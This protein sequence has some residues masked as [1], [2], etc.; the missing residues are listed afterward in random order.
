MWLSWQRT[1][2]PTAIV[3]DETFGSATVHFRIEPA[4][5]S[6]SA[7]AVA[8]AEKDTAKRG[9]ERRRVESMIVLFMKNPEDYAGSFGSPVAVAP[10][11]SDAHLASAP[12]P[13]DRPVEAQT[14]E[15]HNDAPVGFPASIRK[16]SLG[17]GLFPFRRWPQDEPDRRKLREFKSLE[18]F[19]LEACVDANRSDC[20]AKRTLAISSTWRK[21]LWIRSGH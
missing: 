16:P 8:G 1:G 2:S 18:I 21:L 13:I 3:C 5:T 10:A 9:A 15:F 14:E 20:A 17:R 4:G 11:T 7:E 6:C 19:N 12:A